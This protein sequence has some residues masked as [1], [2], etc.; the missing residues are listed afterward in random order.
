MIRSFR[1]RIL[2]TLTLGGAVVMTG[3]TR[4]YKFQAYSMW[5]ESRLKPMETSPDPGRASSSRELIPGTVARGEL[6]VDTALYEGRTEAGALV[7]KVPFAVTQEFLL[8]GQERFNIYCAPCHSRN[9][10]GQ[11]MIVKRGFPQPPDYAIRRLRT[12]PVGHF[13]E[14]MTNGYGAMYSYASRVQPQ[15]RWA[16][17]AYIRALQAARP[18]VPD[19]R[20][21]IKRP[22]AGTVPASPMAGGRMSGQGNAPFAPSAMSPGVAPPGGPPGPGGSVPMAPVPGTATGAMPTGQ[23]AETGTPAP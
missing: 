7:T 16:I 10:D 12:A 1:H 11:G 13:F 9:G 18:V 21:Y 15:D 6:R 22:R 8:R 14:V 3:C 19:T 5:N 4:D 20:P 2:W 23:G 17:A